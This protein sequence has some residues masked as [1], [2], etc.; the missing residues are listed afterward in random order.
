[1]MKRNRRSAGLTLYELVCSIAI[2]ATIFTMLGWLG[3]VACRWRDTA[4]ASVNAAT[5]AD[6]LRHAL[7][8]GACG[9]LP[10]D[11]VT[12]GG[13]SWK[14]TP[15]VLILS[16]REGTLVIAREGSRLERW[17]LGGRAS[18]ETLGAGVERVRFEL[19]RGH[20]GR[21]QGIAFEVKVMGRSAPER[22]FVA[23]RGE[24]AER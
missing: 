21:T 19:A 4:D 20:D 17:R 15:E 13:R 6:R 11:A 3:V 1:M 23:L 14:S 12:A 7:L 9:A 18:R 24:A 2:M 10:I 5:C 16:R 22:G 8:D